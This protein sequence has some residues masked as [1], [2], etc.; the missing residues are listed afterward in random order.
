M[1]DFAQAHPEPVSEKGINNAHENTNVEAASMP[2][3]DQ[4][5]TT[6][7][8]ATTDD[9]DNKNENSQAEAMASLP[10]DHPLVSQSY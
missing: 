9:L 4:A 6:T 5:Q 3:L 8:H 2:N 1:A 7:D 10:A